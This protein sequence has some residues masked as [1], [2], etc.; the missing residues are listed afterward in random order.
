MT[1]T[2]H[3]LPTTADTTT[4]TTAAVVRTDAQAVTAIDELEMYIARHLMAWGLPATALG[5]I[6]G[7]HFGGFAGA[8][9]AAAVGTVVGVLG[10]T[11]IAAFKRSRQ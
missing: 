5:M 2:T 7:Y 3:T 4:D 6:A 8:V 10:G 11:A 1:T 9:P